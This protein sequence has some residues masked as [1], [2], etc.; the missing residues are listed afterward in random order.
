MQFLRT[1]VPALQRKFC[2]K[3]SVLVWNDL[4]WNEEFSTALGCDCQCTPHRKVNFVF[5]EVAAHSMLVWIAGC[6][7]QPGPR[8]A[9]SH[10]VSVCLSFV[11][12]LSVY[13][14]VVPQQT[15]WVSISKNRNQ[16]VPRVDPVDACLVFVLVAGQ[17][18]TNCFEYTYK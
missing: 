5:I 9:A 10:F 15:F 14:S 7:I 13:C 4:C 18:Y 1:L 11:S 16:I 17:G 8:Y 3:H 2:L 12:G 6:Y